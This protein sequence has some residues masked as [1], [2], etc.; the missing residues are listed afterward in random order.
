MALMLISIP[1]LD[2][3]VLPK[4]GH[5]TLVISGFK[6]AY[7]VHIARFDVEIPHV[8]FATR[9]LFKHFFVSTSSTQPTGSTARFGVLQITK[10]HFEM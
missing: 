9:M 7:D 6:L 5:R 2:Q 3:N 4:N 8:T 10:V 1:L